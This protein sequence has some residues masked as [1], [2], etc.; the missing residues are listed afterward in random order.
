VVDQIHLEALGKIYDRLGG[1]N[2]NWALTGSLSF[3]LQGVPVEVHDIDIQTDRAGAYEIERRFS[4]LITRKVEFSEAAGIR[5][6]FGAFV[7]DGIEVEVMGDIQKRLEDGSWEHPVSLG[8]HKKWIEV[9]RMKIPVLSLEYEYDAYLKLGR[10]DKAEVLRNWLIKMGMR[11]EGETAGAGGRVLIRLA[12]KQD[13]GAIYKILSD[14]FKPY[15]QSY[16]EQAYHATASWEGEIQRRI[17]DPEAETLVATYGDE[18]VGTVS[19]YMDTKRR[20]YIRS[21]AVKPGY[22]GR[23]VGRQILERIERIA[24]EKGCRTLVLECYEPLARAQKIYERY[25]FKR[26]GEER[27][28]HGITVFEMTREISEEGVAG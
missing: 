1:A 18:I 19:A 25:G 20:L 24:R 14:A 13:V 16:T 15:K 27:H 23:G 10:K 11:S 4:D 5:S 3:A 12:V 2:I 17:D 28:Y 26:T 7:I 6:Y 21:M 9:Q 8:R 22:Q